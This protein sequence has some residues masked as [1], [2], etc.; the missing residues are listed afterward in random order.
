M[1]SNWR[2]FSAEKNCSRIFTL[3]FLQCADRFHKADKMTFNVGSSLDSGSIGWEVMA[4]CIK[5]ATTLDSDS[6]CLLLL[7]AFQARF[8]N[9]WAVAFLKLSEV[10]R[11]NWA[12]IS[13]MNPGN[14]HKKLL[15]R[16]LP[17]VKLVKATTAYRLTS[18][19]DLDLKADEAAPSWD[20][21]RSSWT[22]RSTWEKPVENAISWKKCTWYNHSLV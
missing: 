15:I 22:S 19:Q 1:T 11:A 3:F 17:N 4:A 18:V 16:P 13:G 10:E 8:R 7:S 2:K 14:P 9:K 20:Q 5:T 21:Q 12:T 6:V